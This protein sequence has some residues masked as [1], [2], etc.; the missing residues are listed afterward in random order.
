MRENREPVYW[1]LGAS[2]KIGLAYVRALEQTEQECVVWG[3]YNQSADELL[4]LQQACRHVR[5]HPYGCDL[6]Q[7]ASVQEMIRTVQGSGH[8]PDHILHLACRKVVYS[9]VRQFDW[10]S[11][12]VQEEI[13]VHSFLEILKVCLPS[14]QKQRY[15]RI[16]VMLSECTLGT[17]P[18]FLSDYVMIKYALLGLVKALAVEYADKGITINGISPAMMETRFLSNLDERV[19][20]N[21]AERAPMKRNAR[22]EETVSAIAFLMSEQA[23]YITG[24]NCNVSGGRYM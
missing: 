3:Q 13:A 18:G 15:G 9:R 8:M 16:G 20:Q 23:S 10:D 19:I 24:S 4:A 1:I 22:I 5:L 6:S 7:G 17:P 2:S 12:A 14:M 11:Y 21:N